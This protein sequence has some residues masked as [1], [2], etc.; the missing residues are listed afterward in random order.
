MIKIERWAKKRPA[1]LFRDD[2]SNY[3]EAQVRL[4]EEAKKRTHPK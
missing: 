1:W 3:E 2:L 4:D